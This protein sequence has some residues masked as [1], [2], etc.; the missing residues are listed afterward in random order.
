MAVYNREQVGS[1]FKPYVLSTAVSQGMNVQT[2]TLD[3][4]DPL[5]IPPDSVPSDTFSANSQPVASGYYEIHNDS[6][7]ENGGF[8]PQLAMAESINTAYAD[9]WHHVGGVAVAKMAQ[10]FGVNTVAAGIT[11]PGGMEDEAGVALGQASLTVSEQATML[12][13]IDDG[14]VYHDAHVISSITQANAQPTPIKITSYP[15]FNQADPTLNADEA[16]QVQYAMSEDTAPYGTAPTAGLSNGQEII[17][18]TGTTNTAQSAFFIGAIPTQAM[19]VG[20]FTDMSNQSLPADLGGNSQGGYGGT[21]PAS[22]WHTYAQD[23][24]VPLGL[25]Q[26]PAPVFTGAKWNEVPPNLRAVPKKKKVKK[27]VHNGNPTGIPSS[28][29]TNP[30][31]FP[32]FSCDPAAVSCD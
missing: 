18:K 4:F 30:Y 32:T 26:F 20:L 17:A 24:F 1:S 3:G 29:V 31:P 9:L 22:I 28:P 5:W 16:T 13:T 23:N 11:G 10:L 2:S 25:E 19:A 21:W 15:V 27:P 8:T 14:G 7:A 12:A 6:T